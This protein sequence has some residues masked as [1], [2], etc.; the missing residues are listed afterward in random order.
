MSE[1]A[2]V[3]LKSGRVSAPAPSPPPPPPPPPPPLWSAG[4]T[5][6]RTWTSGHPWVCRNAA[7]SGCVGEAAPHSTR[8]R[9]VER[10]GGRGGGGE[11]RRGKGR[12][13]QF[14]SDATQTQG[15]HSAPLVV[16]MTFWKRWQHLRTA[17]PRASGSPPPQRNHGDTH[18]PASLGDAG[19]RVETRAPLGVG[20][21]KLP[22]VES[23]AVY[24]YRDGA[25]GF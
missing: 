7:R 5:G 2:Q 10:R 15:G 9:S 24:C 4:G 25:M 11:G 16:V 22:G 23:T 6:T 19:P 18:C 8:R 13:T 12:G 20:E 1:T 14:Q 21:E 17:P 3:E